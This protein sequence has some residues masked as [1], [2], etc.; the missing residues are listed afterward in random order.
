MYEV[1]FNRNK[2]STSLQSKL[3]LLLPSWLVLEKFGV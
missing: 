1:A 2:S 3:L